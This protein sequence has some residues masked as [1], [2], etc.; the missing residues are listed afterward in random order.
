VPLRVLATSL[1]QTFAVIKGPR[2]RSL[3]RS[4]GHVFIPIHVVGCVR[5]DRAQ[6][7]EQ[8]EQTRAI[9]EQGALNHE[10]YQPYSFF[11][12]RVRCGSICLSCDSVYD[13]KAGLLGRGEREETLR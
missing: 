6:I 12:A 13:V 5:M 10:L 8:A 7:Q 1:S 2:L 4:H 9:R 11:A 3:A